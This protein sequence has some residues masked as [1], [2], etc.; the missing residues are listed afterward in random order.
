MV[1]IEPVYHNKYTAIYLLTE[2]GR[3]SFTERIQ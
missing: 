1:F 3:I 2:I